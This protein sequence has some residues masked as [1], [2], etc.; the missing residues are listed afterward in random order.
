MIKLYTW[1]SQPAAY[2]LYAALEGHPCDSS[3]NFCM[4]VDV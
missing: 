3:H 4:D 1:S 2:G